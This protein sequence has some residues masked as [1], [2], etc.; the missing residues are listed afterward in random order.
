ME[1]DIEKDASLDGYARARRKRG[2]KRSGFTHTLAKTL[3]SLSKLGQQYCATATGSCHGLTQVYHRWVVTIYTQ[4]MFRLTIRQ[5][6][7]DHCRLF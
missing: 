2:K 3:P 5:V 7:L 4:Y 1:R 6:K